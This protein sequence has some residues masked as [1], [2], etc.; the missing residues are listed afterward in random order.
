MPHFRLLRSERRRDLPYFCNI[1]I[2]NA[3][4][5]TVNDGSCHHINLVGDCNALLIVGSHENFYR[6]LKR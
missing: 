3:S 1:H 2:E 4:S 6:G 5:G